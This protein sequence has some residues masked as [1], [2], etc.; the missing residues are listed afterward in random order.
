MNLTFNPW[1][2]EGKNGR[3]E[4]YKENKD[5]VTNKTHGYGIHLF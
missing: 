2:E 3:G 4:A 1:L 5:I